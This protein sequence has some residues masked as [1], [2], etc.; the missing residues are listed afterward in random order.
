M[1]WDWSTD[2][3]RNTVAITFSAKRPDAAQMLRGLYGEP[4]ALKSV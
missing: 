1:L 4:L 2:I 3:D